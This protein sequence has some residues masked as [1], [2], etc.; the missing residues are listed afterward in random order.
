VKYKFIFSLNSH[1]WIEEEW[2][3]I[4]EKNRFLI[5]DPDEMRC[6]SQ[7]EGFPSQ[8]YD[9]ERASFKASLIDAHHTLD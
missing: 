7:S 5:T 9:E 1:G 6:H 3:C 2:L 8:R 4:Q